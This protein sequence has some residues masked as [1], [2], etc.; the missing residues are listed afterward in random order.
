MPNKREGHYLR[1]PWHFLVSL[2]EKLSNVN[3]LPAVGPS[4]DWVVILK[5]DRGERRKKKSEDGNQVQAK[6]K[7][8]L[9]S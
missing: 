3:V 1:F 6:E 9:D 7:C 4:S 2:A 8:V 5:R